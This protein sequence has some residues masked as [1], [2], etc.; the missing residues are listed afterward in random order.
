VAIESLLLQPIDYASVETG[1]AGRSAELI[2][3]LL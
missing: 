2:A 3:E 1:T